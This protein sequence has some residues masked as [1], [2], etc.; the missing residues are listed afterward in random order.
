MVPA[1]GITGGISSGVAYFGI[2]RGSSVPPGIASAIALRSPPTPVAKS[3][4]VVAPV[5]LRNVRLEIMTVSP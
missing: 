4:K 3:V 2:A 1:R 5:Y